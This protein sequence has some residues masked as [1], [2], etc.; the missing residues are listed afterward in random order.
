VSISKLTRHANFEKANDL[1]MP[2]FFII[3]AHHVTIV[4]R[5]MFGDRYRQQPVQRK[6]TAMKQ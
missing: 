4:C 6:A 2:F 1:D 3:I 5:V